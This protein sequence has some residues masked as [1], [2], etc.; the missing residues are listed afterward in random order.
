MPLMMDSY[1]VPHSMMQQKG[2]QNFFSYYESRN[3][4]KY[5]K[6]VFFG[7]QAILRK[8]FVGQ[9]VDQS[10]IDFA[11]S[12]SKEHF[13]GADY[14]PR[15]VWEYVVHKHEGKLPL[16]IQAVKEGTPVEVSN[17]MMSVQ[18]TDETINPN[19]GYAY[20]AP[21]INGFETI[22]THVWHPSNVATISYYVRKKFEEAFSKS[23]DE[24]QYWMIDYLLHDFGMRGVSSLESADM[25]GM[26]HLVNFSGT[27]TMSAILAAQ[28]FYHADMVG[29]SVSASEHNVMMGEGRSRE[30]QVVKRLINQFKN[31]IFS[32]VSD[33]Y[34]IENLLHE[35]TQGSLKKEIESIGSAGK[36]VIRPDSPR[37]PGDTCADQV[38]W[39]TRELEKGFGATK[40]KKGYKVLNPKVGII[41]GDGIGPQ[42]I[43]DTVEALIDNGFSAS[44]CVYGMG[45]G[46]LQ[47][48]DRDTQRNAFK[49][50]AAKIDGTW[51]DRQKSP[52]DK[53]K[54]SKAGRLSLVKRGDHFSTIK[55]SECLEMNCLET[56]FENG[57]LVRDM[58]FTEV[59]SC[60]LN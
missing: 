6:T 32:C 18:A 42:D 13:M 2:L 46:L 24:D 60:T 4:A 14:F 19:T 15:D 37:F 52:Q 1:K 50:S 22:L 33:T 44:T 38:L 7:L 48:H 34:S 53:S 39:I 29:H 25:G 35:Y 17:V 51:Q 5:P 41:Y 21:L 57:K 28:E 11:E 58:S 47:K 23:V 9:V 30:I 43:Y 56:V 59:K 3:G 8:Y 40:N 26:G 20:I 10:D 27:D 36:F 45:G 12:F 55:D 54:A 31:A 49:S 16:R